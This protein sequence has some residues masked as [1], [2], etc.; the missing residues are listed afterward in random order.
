M[1][2]EHRK[3]LELA[4][5]QVPAMDAT[6]VSHV[7]SKPAATVGA[8]ATTQKKARVAVPMKA[9]QSVLRLAPVVATP[10]RKKPSRVAAAA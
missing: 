10:I 9:D 1:L 8:A 2:A 3:L 6:A 4:L 7:Q 5:A